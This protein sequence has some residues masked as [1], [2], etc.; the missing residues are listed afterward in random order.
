MACRICHEPENLISICG[1]K[2]TSEFVHEKCI[3]KWIAIKKDLTCEICQQPYKKKFK[4]QLKSA[5]FNTILWFLLGCSTSISHGFLLWR[6]IFNYYRDDI[7]SIIVMSCMFN[8]LISILYSISF[9]GEIYYCG[10]IYYKKFILFV[11][12]FCFFSS[13]IYFQ[14]NNIFSTNLI[15][16]YII[17]F[18]I[19]ICL[20]IVT[21][22]KNNI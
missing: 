16:D 11:W 8:A 4:K 10:D 1:C 2:G 14:I 21:L 7:I 13:S 19:F 3:L 12:T 5:L 20:M 9:C 17:T 22:K 6:H 15:V 18:V